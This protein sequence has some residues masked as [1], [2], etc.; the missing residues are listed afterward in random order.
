[1][2]SKPISMADLAH[3]ETPKP[4]AGY[5][6]VPD[7]SGP[8]PGVV[9]LQDVLG[10]TLE[11]RGLADHMANH[12]YLVFAPDLYEG[13]GI[14]CVRQAMLAAARRAGH[15]FE[16]IEQA[17]KYLVAQPDCTGKVGVIGFCIGGN[18]AL[19]LASGGGFDA[20]STNYGTLLHH[21]R[22]LVQGACPVVGSFGGSDLTIPAPLVRRLRRE[23]DA[24]GVPNDIK[25][26]PRVSH[27]FFQDYSG[28]VGVLMKVAGMSHKP[29]TCADAWERIF[30]FFGTHLAA[31]VDE[32][33]SSTL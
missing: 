14:T 24:A 32:T 3:A 29:D 28:A 11:L 19:T 16:R 12:G 22:E 31:G 33:A 25:I 6:A 13:R 15:T 30:T 1:M 17:R 5:L 8:W 27:A 7:G 20:V 4:G 18:F 9:M 23:L 10:L 21:P 26:Y 2:S